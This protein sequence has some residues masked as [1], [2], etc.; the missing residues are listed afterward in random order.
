MCL[1][2]L[3]LTA[4]ANPTAA[5]VH[6]SPFGACNVQ[7]SLNLDTPVKLK[8][9]LDEHGVA[10]SD[11]AD[12]TTLRTAVV[13]RVKRIKKEAM[14]I[15]T[16]RSLFKE[17]LSISSL[18]QLLNRI[19]RT[20]DTNITFKTIVAIID[21]IS[22]DIVKDKHGVGKEAVCT[23]LVY[24]GVCYKCN[25]TV[26]PVRAYSFTLSLRDVQDSTIKVNV[27]ASHDAG[28]QLF[29]CGPEQYDALNATQQGDVVE[30]AT[31]VKVNIAVRI[32]WDANRGDAIVIAYAIKP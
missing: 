1:T 13:R 19:R 16:Q 20:E 6:H 25:A 15:S 8:R 29:A 24:N 30:K 14:P 27:M 5:I 10:Y 28:V 2:V 31:E 3:V 17:A 21:D 18:V 12:E 11:D 7:E 32:S 26:D 22:P 4:Q 23:G 9:W